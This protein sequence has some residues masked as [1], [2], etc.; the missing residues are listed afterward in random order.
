[1]KVRIPT[2]GSNAW[3]PL[4]YRVCSNRLSSPWRQTHVLDRTRW[5]DG[6]EHPH[7]RLR[8]HRQYVTP[9]IATYRATTAP[10]MICRG[11]KGLGSQQ[12]VQ[13][14]IEKSIPHVR[15]N[16]TLDD[17]ISTRLLCISRRRHPEH[18]RRRRRCKHS[19][20]ERFSSLQYRNVG[21]TAKPNRHQPTGTRPHR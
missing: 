11:Q 13:H 19:H 12:L 18:S 15:G 9:P 4:I 6:Y 17:K 1:M 10:L 21:P 3:L 7:W 20:N 8:E 16:G 14:L 2:T 5:T